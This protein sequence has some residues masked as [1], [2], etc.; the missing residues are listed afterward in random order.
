VPPA[1][2]EGGAG[3]E[4]GEGGATQGGKHSDAEVWAWM[5]VAVAMG[6]LVVQQ[7]GWWL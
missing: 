7:V 6:Y 4:A 2:E 5:M 3:A 1:E